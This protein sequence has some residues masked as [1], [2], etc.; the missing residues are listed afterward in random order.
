[1]GPIQSAEGYRPKG[2]RAIQKI[3]TISSRV[4]G[5]SRIRASRNAESLLSR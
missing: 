2:F 3:A 1:M 5:K 4:I